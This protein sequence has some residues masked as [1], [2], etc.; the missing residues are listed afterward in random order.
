MVAAQVINVTGKVTDQSGNPLPGVN[1]LYKSTSIGTSTDAGG[2]YSIGVPPDAVLL[3]SFIGFLPQEVNVGGQTII[4]VQLVEETISLNEVV[5]TA[6]GIKREVKSLGYSVSEVKSEEIN[7][8]GNSNPISALSGKV[9]GVSI[10]QTSAGPSGSSRVVIRGLSEIIGDNQPLYVI[11]GIPV[12]N[13]TLG[14]AGK[15]GGYDMGD[16][17]SDINPEDIQSISVLKGASASALYGSRAQNGVVL[18]TTKS[19]KLHQGI[20]V[21]VSTSITF[22]EVYNHFD[23]YQTKYG[24]GSNDSLPVNSST[25]YINSVWGQRLDPDISITYIDGKSRPYIQRSNSIDEFF[26]TGVTNVN[27]VS[28]T[29]GNENNSIRLSISNTSNSDIVPESGLNRYG[30][31]FRSFSKLGKRLRVDAKITYNREEV[32]NR[33]ALGD[34]SNNIG[35]TLAT[36]GPDID[37]SMLKNYYENE[38]GRYVSWTNSSYSPNPYWMIY[39]TSNYSE[40]NRYIGL[41]SFDLDLIKNLT[42]NVKGGLDR[43]DMQFIDYYDKFTPNIESGTLTEQN[44]YIQESNIS[45]QLSYSGSFPENFGYSISVG[46]NVSKQKYKGIVNTGINAS[47]V[48][49]ISLTNYEE[50]IISP[51]EESK[52]IQSLYGFGQISYKN[53]FFIDITARKDWSSSLYSFVNNTAKEVGYFYPSIST[54]LIV[55]DIVKLPSLFS[56]AKIRA[57]WAQIGND[58][59]PLMTGYTYAYSN[60]SLN[61]YRFASISGSVAPNPYLKPQKTTSVEAGFDVR[62]V[63]N[64][65]G[66]DMAY[67][68]DVTEDMILRLPVDPTSGFNERIANTGEIKNH[69]IELLLNTVP[70]NNRNLKWSVDINFSKNWNEVVKLNNDYDEVDIAD[71]R[72]GGVFIRAIEGEEY[73]QIWGT[74]YKL[75]DSGERIIGDGTTAQLGL[76]VVENKKLGSILPDW[77]GG[78]RSDVS[79][80]NFNLGIAIDVRMGGDIYSMTN[81]SMASSGTSDITL[82][83]RD[84]KEYIAEGINEGTG[85]E[86]N[87]TVQPGTYWSYIGTNVAEEFI[88]DASFVKLREFTLGY[89]VPS[90]LLDKV[91]VKGLTISFVG[92]NLWTIFKNAPNIDPE[93][94]YNNG[95]GQGLEY[96]SIPTRKHYGF[97]VSFKF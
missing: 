35:K 30:I 97:K 22:D 53:Y 94:T 13:G 50:V 71:A 14:Q 6:L 78:I 96:G 42:L 95:N 81:S 75:N 63:K 46:G 40:K 54:S 37:P 83:G 92:R 77:T 44:H 74:G 25:A 87:V 38:F 72:W 16:G 88:Y 7:K 21:E 18:I 36:W 29:G 19:G 17:L 76:P 23:T 12:Q 84:E 28:F 4:N 59:D 65:I 3:F 57:S 56:F 79:Y 20:G 2:D 69:G 82:E 9:A 1:V 31:N 58:P 86:N 80:K 62:L 85:L 45:S 67:Y 27:N 10:V 73:G 52:E 48:G 70:I 26:R 68:S 5:V 34:A 32:D 90:K 66:L 41:L 8:S 89:S 91:N 64:R 47:S 11:D 49:T 60:R 15:Y 51:F 24:I 43:Y 55:S 33:P 93:S 61:G 39:K